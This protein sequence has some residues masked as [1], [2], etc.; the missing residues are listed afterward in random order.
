MREGGREEGSGKEVVR[1]REKERE[2]ER[3]QY[4]CNPLTYSSHNASVNQI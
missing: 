3:E 1:E 2:R 4:M